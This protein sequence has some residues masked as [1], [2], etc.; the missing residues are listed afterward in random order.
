MR[1]ALLGTLMT[2]STVFLALY[3]IIDF[4]LEH[5]PT[6]TDHYAPSDNGESMSLYA[7]HQPNSTVLE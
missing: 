1:K 3:V 4:T 6:L 7:T 5:H 2:L